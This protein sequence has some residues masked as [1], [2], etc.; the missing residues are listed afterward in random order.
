VTIVLSLSKPNATLQCYPRRHGHPGVGHSCPDNRARPCRARQGKVGW[1]ATH[2]FCQVHDHCDIFQ[3]LL[4]DGIGAVKL[5]HQVLW[6]YVL[7]S[8]DDI[9]SVLFRQPGTAPARPAAAATAAVSSSTSKQ[10]S[11]QQQQPYSTASASNTYCLLHGQH[12]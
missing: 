8:M 5:E 6:E 1:G 3:Q 2:R 4:P 7:D 12:R 11:S 9:L 10:A